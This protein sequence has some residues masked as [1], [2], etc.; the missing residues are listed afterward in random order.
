[1]VAAAGAE[2]S[3][4][5][6]QLAGGDR[7]GVWRGQVLASLLFLPPLLLLLVVVVVSAV[8]DAGALRSYCALNRLPT[9]YFALSYAF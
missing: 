2:S 7:E 9:P 4:L 8:V 5:R 6:K 1:M 3:V